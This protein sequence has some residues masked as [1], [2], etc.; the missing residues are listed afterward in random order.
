MAIVLKL[1]FRSVQIAMDAVK[2]EAQAEART[3]R[4]A[5]RSLPPPHI[6]RVLWLIKI[7]KADRR[8]SK[9]QRRREKEQRRRE[10]ER[11]IELLRRRQL[12]VERLE[13][14]ITDDRCAQSELMIAGMVKGLADFDV[15]RADR[16]TLLVEARCTHRVYVATE[17]K[18]WEA[19]RETI[20]E[21]NAECR[22]SHG[23]KVK[24]KRKDAADA[25]KD[26]ANLGRTAERTAMK[27]ARESFWFDK[28]YPK[29]VV[30]L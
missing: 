10:K 13:D 8:N 1:I 9:E 12:A 6:K 29:N 11:A 16:E 26:Y 20:E 25:E 5:R 4:A 23:E 18:R 22:L 14:D 28:V 24:G 3:Q 17:R 30:D 15:L 21:R 7:E 27:V 19:E 2:A